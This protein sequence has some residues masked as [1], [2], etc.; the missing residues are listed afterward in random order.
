MLIVVP[1]QEESRIS[2]YGRND[3][4]PGAEEPGKFIPYVM[5]QS[6]QEQYAIQGA[7]RDLKV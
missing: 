3:S 7:L 1:G 5:A 6:P 2:D 4:C